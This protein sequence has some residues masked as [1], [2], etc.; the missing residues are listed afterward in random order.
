M[1]QLFRPNATLHARLALWA[2]LLGA[3]ALAGIAWAHSRSDWTTGVD[4]HVAQPIPFSHEHH[5]GD[6]GIDCRYCHH[7]VEDQAF[8]GLPTSELCMHCHAELFADAPTLAPVR[9]SFAAGAPL[10]WWRVHDL[11]DFVFFDHGAHVRNGVGCETCH[12]RVDRMPRVRRAA[13]LRMPWCVECHEDPS[14]HLRPPDAIVAMGWT[15][16]DD[17]DALARAL[18]EFYDARPRTSCSECHR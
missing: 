16:P 4:R 11:P 5:V 8:A 9:E 18:V 1:A 6:A 13:D 10:R 14:P 2:V 3:G 17:R 15:P 7:S 12:G